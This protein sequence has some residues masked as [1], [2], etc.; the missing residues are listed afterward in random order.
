MRELNCPGCSREMKVLTKDGVEIDQCIQCG[1]IWLDS[2]ELEGLVGIDPGEKRMP[3]CP[4]CDS[5]L[6]LL[7]LRS[8]EVDFC[9]RCQ[10][11][12]LDRGELEE[13][14]HTHHDEFRTWLD[15]KRNVE[16]AKDRVEE[17]RTDAIDNVFLMAK[18]G[19][20]VASC[21]PRET[22]GM[23]E[24]L[25]AGMLTVVQDFVGTAFSSI[26]TVDLESIDVGEKRLL[27][28]QGKYTILAALVMD[29]KKVLAEYREKMERGLKEIEDRYG[30]VL[31]NW[32]GDLEKLKGIQ[33]AVVRVFS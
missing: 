14:T 22:L 2:G 31:E 29:E 21:A 11:V 23:D 33:K 15:F 9:P 4:G 24:D 18:S 5:A 3:S 30:S 10:G 17:L 26:T 27:L 12:F 1:G 25:L 16:V 28:E 20:L 7:L 13:L 8:V 32:N 19:I 6:S